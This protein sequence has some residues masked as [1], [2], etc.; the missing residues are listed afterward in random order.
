MLVDQI[1]VFIYLF[2]I[3]L[4]LVYCLKPLSI[5]LKIYDNGK[6]ISR[7]IHNN[8]IL[9]YGGLISVIYFFLIIKFFILPDVIE[10]VMAI[11]IV[12]FMQGF[13]DD[14]L[15]LT[16][17]QKLIFLFFP[18][19]FLMITQ[20]LIIYDFGN[21]I[22][23]TEINLGK[24]SFLVTLLIIFL[25]INSINYI[26]GID[27]MLCMQLTAS[28]LFLFFISEDDS[29]KKSIL[30]ILIPIIINLFFNF[31]ILGKLKYFSGNSGALM[32]GFI[33]SFFGIYLYSY[34]NIHPS[35]IC[36]CFFLY[37]YDFI[38]VNI[39]RLFKK[40]SLLRADNNHVHHDILKLTKSH[41]KSSLI[42]FLFSFL[43]LFL[44]KI[45]YQ[46]FLGYSYDISII[47]FVLYF[48]FYCHLRNYIKTNFK[49]TRK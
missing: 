37:I 41:F 36:W 46:E 7:K 22:F 2:L 42:L 21:Y 16:P 8:K 4:V 20:D 26:D 10:T 30:F 35:I 34:E 44:V 18:I 32:F 29:F 28:F 23:F 5:K 15:N 14:R 33:L 48:L 27:G 1:E 47:S 11:S 3:Y 6:N 19:I 24:F 49:R 25:S 12:V 13:M 39:F 38:Y 17:G 43:T 45:L 9:N 31:P 40:R